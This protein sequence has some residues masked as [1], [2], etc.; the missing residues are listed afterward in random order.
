MIKCCAKSCLNSSYLNWPISRGNYNYFFP[1]TT[2]N[3][4]NPGGDG[5]CAPN[6][7]QDY[8]SEVSKKNS[9][10]FFI[11]TQKKMTENHSVNPFLY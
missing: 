5:R 8:P 6:G 4:S 2:Y 1:V 10:Q 11:C 7:L 9:A 3:T